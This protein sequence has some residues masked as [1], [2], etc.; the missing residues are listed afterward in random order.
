MNGYG[1]TDPAAK[2]I[3]L[4]NNNKM[5]YRPNDSGKNCLICHSEKKYYNFLIDQYRVEECAHCGMMRLNPQPSDAALANIYNENYFLTVSEDTN[6]LHA[7]TLKSAT[8]KRY[9]DLLHSYVKKPLA[10][11]LLEIGCGQGDF[12]LKAFEHGLNVTGIEFSEYAVQIA[13]KKLGSKA[14]IIHGEITQLLNK[15]KRFDFIVFADVLEHVRNPR[16]FLK[17]T[18][19]LLKEEG[20]IVAIVPSIDSFSARVMTKK[21]VEFKIE[22][23]WYFSKKTLGWLCY[24]ENFSELKIKKAKKTLSFDYITKHFERYPI[25]PLTKI[26]QLLRKLTPEYIRR[27]PINVSAGGIIAFARKTA[28]KS[29]KK[30]SVIMAVYNEEKTVQQTIDSVLAKSSSQFEIQ[31]IIIESNSTDNSKTIVKQYEK[32]PRVSIIWQDK[33]YG[34]GYAIRAGLEKAEGDYILIQDADNEY[35]IEDYD[36]LI[37]PLITGETAFVLGARHGGKIWKMRTFSN[38]YLTGHLLNLGHY[39]FAFL[40]N[41]FFGLRLKDPFTMYKVFRKDC[42][43]DIQFECDR[44]DFDLELLIKLVCKGYKPIEI[45]VNYQSR[46]FKEGKKIRLFRDP[47]TWVKVIFKLRFK[48]KNYT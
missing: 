3:P 44:F 7:I 14:E 45:P 31:L 39:C 9:L 32:N 23:L 41:T 17:Q 38:Q 24:S 35:D 2:T 30:L 42:L 43:R 34:K 18:H 40:L 13:A 33:P 37:D 20:I 12:L 15:D 28:S 5:K 48:M 11:E 25:Q 1:A 10:G 4:K 8:A 19:S 36:I 6:D 22:H 46:S 27:K 16:E 26:L 29:R 21:W 47:L